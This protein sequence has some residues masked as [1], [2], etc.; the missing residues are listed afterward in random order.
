[1]QHCQLALLRMVQYTILMNEKSLRE[2]YQMQTRNTF[3][4]FLHRELEISITDLAFIFKLDKATVS[5]IVKHG[6]DINIDF[7]V[8]V[9]L[10]FKN[11][12][13]DKS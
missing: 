12:V 1:M 13:K 3:I 5:R 4:L 9:S 8:A 6:S 7:L 11:L 2:E 10:A